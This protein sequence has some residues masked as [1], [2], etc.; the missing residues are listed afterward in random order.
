MTHLA[1][2]CPLFLGARRCTGC[3]GCASE[4]TT[5]VFC[6]LAFCDSDL[7]LDPYSDPSLPIWSRCIAWYDPPVQSPGPLAVTCAH[8]TQAVSPANQAAHSSFRRPPGTARL[9][10]AHV[11]K[12]PGAAMFPTA[13]FRGL[14]EPPGFRTRMSSSLLALPCFPELSS[15]AC[16]HRLDSS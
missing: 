14:W 15:E 5:Q 2:G 4:A 6:S 11:F 1:V 7:I 8:I 13:A 10:H 12:P 16:R 9:P 3:R